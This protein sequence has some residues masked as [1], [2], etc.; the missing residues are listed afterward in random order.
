MSNQNAREK[1]KYESPILVPLG[2]MA[3]GSG[4]C[5]A[6]SS[7]VAP[8]CFPGAADGGSA[9]LA[10]GAPAVATTDC[11]AGGTATQ[12][13]T[14]GPTAVRDCTAGTAALRA[15]SAGTAALAACTAGTAD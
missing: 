8:A 7:V 10:G 14:A 5:T 13:C 1:A 3:K 11:T 12:D 4:V 2:E 9:C 6:G 15:C